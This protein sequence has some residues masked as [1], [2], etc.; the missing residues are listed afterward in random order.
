MDEKKPIISALRRLRQ[1]VQGFQASLG[2]RETTETKIS[3]G[4]V[5]MSQGC[6]LFSIELT[7]DNPGLDH[8]NLAGFGGAV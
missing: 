3:S 4:Q 7:G 5:T 8:G 2:Y 6:R 1:E